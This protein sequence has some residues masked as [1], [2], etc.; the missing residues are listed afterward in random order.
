MSSK[1]NDLQLLQRNLQNTVVQQQQMHE[2]LNELNSAL[3]QLETTGKAYKII[4]KVMVASRKEE[5]IKE[6]SEKKEIMD[7]RLK[8][9]SIQENKLKESIEATQ[10]EMVADLQKEK[11][12]KE[13]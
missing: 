2:Q 9:F 6:L 10:K 8:N 1:I 4:G 12:S 7:V 11:T 13:E 3:T 5:L